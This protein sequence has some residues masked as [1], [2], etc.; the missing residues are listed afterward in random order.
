MEKTCDYET[1]VEDLKKGIILETGC[2]EEEIYF[3][4]QGTNPAIKGDRLL[5]ILNRDGDMKDAFAIRTKEIYENYGGNIPIEK[6]IQESVQNAAY[7]KEKGFFVQAARLTDYEKMKD[8][9]ILRLKNKEREGEEL[10]HEIYW[11]I[12]DI[13]IVLY[14][15][16]GNVDGRVITMKVHKGWLNSWGKT[17]EKVV[18]KAMGNMLRIMPPRIYDFWE[19]L[20]DLE[21]K[22]KEFMDTSKD[23]RIDKYPMGTCLSTK[24][25][26]NGAAVIFIPEVAKR[27]YQ[28]MGN[29]YYLVFTSIHELMVHNDKT[30]A[31]EDLRIALRQTMEEA[32]PWE[33][34][35]TTHIYH[36]DEENGFVVAV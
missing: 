21:Y 1:F 14:F 18:S 13:A 3:V 17:E 24:I 16:L 26:T 34:R 28:L 36:Y 8:T 32:T 6:I 19:M 33:D 11:S 7:I 9:L 4:K 5:W 12:G 22:G 31:P 2:K 35:L 30:V 10:D 23:Y 29:G 20:S 27:I 15:Y 25:Y